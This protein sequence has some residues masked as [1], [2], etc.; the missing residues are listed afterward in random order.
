MKEHIKDP[1]KLLESLDSLHQSDIAHSLKKSI[2]KIQKI[3]ILF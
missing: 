3:F 2:K 1:K